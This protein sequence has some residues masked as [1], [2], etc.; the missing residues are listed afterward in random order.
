MSDNFLIDLPTFFAEYAIAR[1]AAK[2][3]AKSKRYDLGIR[4]LLNDLTPEEQSVFDNPTIVDASEVEDMTRYRKEI[5][6]VDRELLQRLRDCTL[7]DLKSYRA[8]HVDLWGADKLQDGLLVPRNE[9]QNTLQRARSCAGHI[10][11]HLHPELY[12]AEDAWQWLCGELRPQFENTRF[13]P[14]RLYAYCKDAMNCRADSSD[15]FSEAMKRLGHCTPWW[16]NFIRE[17]CASFP[18]LAEAMGM[19]DPASGESPA[20]TSP[21]LVMQTTYVDARRGLFVNGANGPPA[22]TPV[23]QPKRAEC[24]GRTPKRTRFRVP[25]I[26]Q[27]DA[28][29]AREDAITNAIRDLA[30]K[31]E[32]F[33]SD[34]VSKKCTGSDGRPIPAGTI[35]A[36]EAWKNRERIASEIGG[37]PRNDREDYFSDTDNDYVDGSAKTPLDE[38]IEQEDA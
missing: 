34:A 7:D 27:D 15:D 28:A 20:A 26:C 23:D 6:D 21:P 13:D 35:R 8:V 22:E 19:P 3:D 9:L 16:Y 18:T 36:S 12:V 4:L 11:R 37:S 25:K 38:M 32:S 14:L 17:F 1:H 24:K 33:T 31:N 10:V 29:R 30:A 2:S 5:T